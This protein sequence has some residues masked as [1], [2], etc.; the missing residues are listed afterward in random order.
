[1]NGKR[2]ALT[3]D[4]AF[5]VYVVVDVVVVVVVVGVGVVGVKLKLDLNSRILAMNTFSSA[6][7]A[8]S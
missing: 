6:T 2:L 8:T 3:S 7:S 5:V 1:M 4:G